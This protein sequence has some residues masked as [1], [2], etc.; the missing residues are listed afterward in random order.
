MCYHMN[1]YA[2]KSEKNRICNDKCSKIVLT[3]TAILLR[4]MAVFDQISQ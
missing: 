1:Y 2:L 4:S 3:K